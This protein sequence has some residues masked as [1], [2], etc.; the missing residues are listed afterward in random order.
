MG[1][2]EFLKVVT[3]ELIRVG[4]VGKAEFLKILTRKP[5]A[6]RPPGLGK[7]RPAW[8]RPAR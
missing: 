3:R 1:K 5:V 6:L 8:L 7:R 2:A 4:E